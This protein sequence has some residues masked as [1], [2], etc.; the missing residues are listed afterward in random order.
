MSLWPEVTR[1]HNF[2]K[3]QVVALFRVILPLAKDIFSKRHNGNTTHLSWSHKL[4]KWGV[5]INGS[6]PKNDVF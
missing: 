1:K 3:L 2:A 6:I 4:P 5:S